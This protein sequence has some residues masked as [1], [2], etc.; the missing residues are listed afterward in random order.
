MVNLW[1]FS[2]TPSGGPAVPCNALLLTL[3]GIAPIN[4]TR[5]AWMLLLRCAYFPQLPGEHVLPPACVILR[6]QAQ[7]QASIHATSATF[8]RGIPSIIAA[9]GRPIYFRP[10]LLTS[11][12]CFRSG[13][14]HC[15]CLATELFCPRRASSTQNG[16]GKSR[17]TR[18]GNTLRWRHLTAS[19]VRLSVALLFL[20]DGDSSEQL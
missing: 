5:E 13:R 20:S 8:S 15:Y 6:G 3:K 17:N 19:L 16:K 2:A 11:H 12:D 4:R 18:A 14:D 9:S 1:P 10:A 7:H